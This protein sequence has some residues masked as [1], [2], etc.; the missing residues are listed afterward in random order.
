MKKLFPIIFSKANNL[1]SL[2]CISSFTSLCDVVEN[3]SS[4]GYVGGAYKPRARHNEDL[5][6]ASRKARRGD[7]GVGCSVIN[8]DW[9]RVAS[10]KSRIFGQVVAYRFSVLQ[11]DQSGG[12]DHIKGTAC[13]ALRRNSGAY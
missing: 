9:L 8:Q 11:A 6:A 1:C 7:R 4:A 13:E 5:A 10:S 2:L 3:G 12:G